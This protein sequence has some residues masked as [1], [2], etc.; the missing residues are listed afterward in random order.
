ME[1]KK[2]NL[3]NTWL[4]LPK[5]KIEGQQKEIFQILEGEEQIT[6]KIA[7]AIQ[8]AQREIA[9][10]VSENDMPRFYNSGLMEKLEARSKA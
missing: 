6:L 1:S 9:L 4:S 5:P 8:N 2:K 3:I 10:F 7:E